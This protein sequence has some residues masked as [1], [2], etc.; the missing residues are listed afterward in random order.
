MAEEMREEIQ[1]AREYAREKVMCYGKLYCEMRFTGHGNF[2]VS[3]AN[4]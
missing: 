1:V 2:R 3:C 4:V